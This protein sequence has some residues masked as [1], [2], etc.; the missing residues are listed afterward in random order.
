MIFLLIICRPNTD[1]THWLFQFNDLVAWR[2]PLFW[3]LSSDVR[4]TLKVIIRDS[5]CV[6]PWIKRS[7]QMVWLRSLSCADAKHACRL[8]RV[9]L[10]V[11][12]ML[13]QTTYSKHSF[14]DA[15][16]LVLFQDHCGAKQTINFSTTFTKQMNTKEMS[17]L[18]VCIWNWYILD[19][20]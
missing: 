9:S 5:S 16:Y 6:F 17:A 8:L 7:I 2:W 1:S 19:M 3:F 14:V 18:Y 13:L 4:S 11:C 20:L 15:H 12:C 10:I